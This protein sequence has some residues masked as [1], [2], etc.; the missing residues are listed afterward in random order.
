[1]NNKVF[2]G[3]KA[4]SWTIDYTVGLL[5][6]LVGFGVAGNL[7]LD[8]FEQNAYE[9]VVQ[10]ALRLSDI[11]MSDGYPKDWSQ[12]VSFDVVRAGV[13]Y[14]GRLSWRKLHEFTLMNESTLKEALPSAYNFAFALNTGIGAVCFIGST[15]PESTNVST[16][17]FQ[18]AYYYRSLG[19]DD[20]RTYM[21]ANNATVYQ[22]GELLNMLEDAH[23]YGVMVF[24][25]AAFESVLNSTFS[26][27]QL[28]E[29]F[30][31]AA[32]Y[33]P[34]IIIVGGIDTPVLGV[35]G[36]NETN[37]TGF[38]QAHIEPYFLFNE[39]SEINFTKGNDISFLPYE[40]GFLGNLDGAS[41]EQILS[42]GLATWQ[43]EDSRV[44]YFASSQG[45]LDSYP[46]ID[47][48]QQGIFRATIQSTVEC[49]IEPELLDT[50]DLVSIKRIVLDKGSLRELTLYVWRNP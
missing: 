5:L 32:K 18:S 2:M 33:S 8:T 36:T 12:S 9:N 45:T 20:L 6:F 40:G 7:I 30:R 46:L 16:T 34:T 19:D 37:L 31:Q 42:Q 21:L 11:L 25:D 14:D 24:E 44:Y 48:I 27:A 13:L 22:D 35:N 3:K 23:K 4:Q 28:R 38:I 49:S 17:Y 15:L 47:I 50:P 39:S 29:S 26:D 10:D 41:R 1:M 43:I